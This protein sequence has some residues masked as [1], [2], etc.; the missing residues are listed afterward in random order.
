MMGEALTPAEITALK[1][2]IFSSLH[3]ALPGKV[4]SYNAEKGM[5]DI[6]PGLLGTAGNS[7]LPYPLLRDVPV[8][9]PEPREIEPGAFCLVIFA[10]I[11]IDAWIDS[12]EDGLVGSDRMHS[13]SD[14]FAF[15]GFKAGLAE[16]IVE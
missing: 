10:D 5:A 14:A 15:V 13:L 1:K 3:C 6:Q 12:G 7:V 2:D 11:N 8:Y 16:E 9:L 4:V